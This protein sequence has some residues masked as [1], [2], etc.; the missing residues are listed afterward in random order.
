MPPLFHVERALHMIPIVAISNQ[1]GGVGKTTSVI[2]LAA[3]CGLAG[4][5][6]LVIDNDP[7]GN[8]SSVLGERSTGTSIYSGGLPTPCGNRPN[9]WL[10][11]AGQDLLEQEQVLGRK[12]GGR[13]ALKQRLAP[14]TGEFDIVF[15]D[16]PPNLSLLPINALIAAS[17]LV[18]PL[19]CEYYALEGLSQLLGYIN[20]LR[21]SA[22]TA[23]E[24]SGILLTMFDPGHPLAL[25]VEREV[26][27]HFAE[28]VLPTVIPRD[29]S[30][31]AAPSHG[32][33]IF[34]YEPLSNGGIAYLAAAK[35]LLHGL[36]R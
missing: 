4:L 27:Q 7:Q 16:C 35:E 12:S 28:R 14:F 18:V 5:K 36:K 25:E 22:E 9:L 21:D 33:T 29:V 23:L 11:P 3:A 34:D 30:L 26:R 10:I 2:N 20:E 31:A 19:Q 15:I 32:K 13:T 24:L 8:A 6:T 17:H 1:K